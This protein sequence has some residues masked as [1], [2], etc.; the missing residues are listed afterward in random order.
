[1]YEVKYIHRE[2]IVKVSAKLYLKIVLLPELARG[3][4][5]DGKQQETFTLRIIITGET[6]VHLPTRYIFIGYHDA[7]SSDSDIGC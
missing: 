3:M 6:Y 5:H 2:G 1:M 7:W 4:W